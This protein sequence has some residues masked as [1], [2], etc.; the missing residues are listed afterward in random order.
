M[1]STSVSLL[2]RLQSDEREIAWERFVELYAPLIYRWGRHHG[3]HSADA[4]ELLQDV[5]TTL[6]VK[7]PE[8][9]YDPNRRFRSWLRTVTLNRA[10]DLHRRN[11]V[12]PS[13]GHDE[14]LVTAAVATNVDMFE[15]AEYRRFLVHRAMQVMREEFRDDSWQA[16]WQHVVEGRKAAEIAK[17]L[18]ITVNMVYLAKSRILK[19]L[20]R[21]LDGLLE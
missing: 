7:L 9:Q 21:E 17:D 1:D 6:V 8:F 5:L 11:S 10:N 20:R 14:T 13:S 19:R 12:R 2:R 18:G 16:V 3:L 4:S 15:E